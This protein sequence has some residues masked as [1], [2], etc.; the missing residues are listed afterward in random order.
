MMNKTID[1]EHVERGKVARCDVDNARVEAVCNK[2]ELGWTTVMDDGENMYGIRLL[3]IIH[4]VGVEF[5]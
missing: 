5:L 1:D 2:E 3:V 4:T